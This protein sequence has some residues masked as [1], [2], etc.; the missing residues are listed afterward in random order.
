MRPKYLALLFVIMS[1]ATL[2]RQAAA[3]V[4]PADQSR[5]I[6]Y[7]NFTDFTSSPSG[8]PNESILLSPVISV[9]AADK[10]DAGSSMSWNELVVS[11]NAD[12]PPE[13]W[14]KVEAKA[15]FPDHETKYYTMGIWSRESTE[16]ERTSVKGQHDDDGNVKQDTLVLNRQGGKVQLRLTLGGPDQSTQ[17]RLR[18]L[19]LSFFDNKAK[20]EP[21]AP[22]KDVWGKSIDTPELSQFSYPDESG[23]CSAT[24]TTMVLQRWSHILN[25]PE[26]HIDVP[27]TVKAVIDHAYGTGNWPFNT[28]FAGSFPGMR[29]YVARFSD[30]S[31]LEDWIAAGIPVVI[32]ARWDLLLPGRPKDADGHLTVCIGFTKDGDPVINDPAAHFNRGQKVRHIYKRADVINAWHSSHN[33]VYLVYPEDAKVPPDRFG[34]WDKP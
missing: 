4:S 5:F 11:W 14:L 12:A 1:A 30:V 18:F 25:R 22:R 6:G 15:I 3:D 7:K 29:A 8:R 9:P 21:L 34:H 28:A 32:S 27:Q 31:E 19:G 24:S 2:P 33:T 20:V 16:H 10:A 23:W 26:M 17:P 13:T